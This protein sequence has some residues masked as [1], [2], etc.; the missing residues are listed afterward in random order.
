VNN[1][2]AVIRDYIILLNKLKGEQK[3]SQLKQ[4]A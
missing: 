2:Y 3:L 4:A 1:L